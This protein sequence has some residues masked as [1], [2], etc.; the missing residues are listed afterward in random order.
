MAKE[1]GID[2]TALPLVLTMQHVQKI[3][4]LSKKKTYELPHRDGF[5][6]IRCGY[7][8]GVQTVWI[9][10]PAPLWVLRRSLSILTPCMGGVPQTVTI[11]TFHRITWWRMPSRSASL[12]R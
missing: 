7:S 6:V 4:K 2:L 10:I 5:P 12:P 11:G 1:P 9:R 3:A 8:G